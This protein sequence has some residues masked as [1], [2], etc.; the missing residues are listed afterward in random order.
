MSRNDTPGPEAGS[1]TMTIAPR[2][3][4]AVAGRGGSATAVAHAVALDKRVL[5]WK[6]GVLLT[7][8]LCE[9]IL[10]RFDAAMPR[11]RELLRGAAKMN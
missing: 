7:A 11:A 8:A 3:A 6:P 5:Q 2:D 4:T 1:M 10:D 9:E